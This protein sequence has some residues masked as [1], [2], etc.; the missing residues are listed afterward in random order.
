MF[1]WVCFEFSTFLLLKSRILYS[2]YG[3]N[4]FMSSLQALPVEI[5]RNTFNTLSG[6]IFHSWSCSPFPI[7]VL[8]NGI[9]YEQHMQQTLSLVVNVREKWYRNARFNH[10]RNVPNTDIPI[11]NKPYWNIVDK[12]FTLIGDKSTLKFSCFFVVDRL[13]H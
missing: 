8:V 7:R 5:T 2:P 12:Y 4:K 3:Y 10:D 9:F 6:N 11:F 1:Y 13:Q